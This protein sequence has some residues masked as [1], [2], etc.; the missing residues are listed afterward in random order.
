MIGWLLIAAVFAVV[1]AAMYYF[2]KH[3]K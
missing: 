2:W 3:G 1:W